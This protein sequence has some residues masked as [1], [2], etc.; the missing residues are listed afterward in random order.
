MYS[1]IKKEIIYIIS[2]V[3]CLFCGCSSDDNLSI[4]YDNSI[5]CEDDYIAYI[6]ENGS[7]FML[8]KAG[9]D[10]AEDI[11]GLKKIQGGMTFIV[12]LYEDGTMCLWDTYT[13]SVIPFDEMG[14]IAFEH[15]YP[16]FELITKAEDIQDFYYIYS[17]A[18]LLLKNNKWYM[19]DNEVNKEI[20]SKMDCK[21][22]KKI[23][24]VPGYYNFMVLDEKGAISFMGND[25]ILDNYSQALKWHDIIDMDAC[26]NTIVGVDKNGRVRS[27][28]TDVYEN[29][30]GKVSGWDNIKMVIVEN[31]FTAGLTNDGK[32]LIS[33]G[34]Y[35]FYSDKRDLKKAEEWSNIVFISSANNYIMG[36]DINGK[37]WVT[38]PLLQETIDHHDCPSVWISQA[39]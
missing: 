3:I 2:C 12:M 9:A 1:S 25:M 13:K 28:L 8:D 14:S 21:R 38:D 23:S 24:V 31:N 4:R 29:Y 17:E 39:E 27:T 35:S 33:E 26:E 15:F 7:L 19:G 22:I 10:Y 20:C 11:D 30:Y 6:T 5:V 16:A 18:I 36:I 34:L 37:M 32:V